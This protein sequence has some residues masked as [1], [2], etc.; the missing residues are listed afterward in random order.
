M[1][2]YFFKCCVTNSG[3]VK[4][5]GGEFRLTQLQLAPD[6]SKL[7]VTKSTALSFINF[8]FNVILEVK[9]EN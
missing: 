6:A 4:A 8:L 7:P 1:L 2:K 9:K 3:G 5:A